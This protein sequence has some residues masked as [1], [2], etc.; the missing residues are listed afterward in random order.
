LPK[1]LKVTTTPYTIFAEGKRLDVASEQRG[2]VT[3]SLDVSHEIEDYQHWNDVPSLLLLGH[4]LFDIEEVDACEITGEFSGTARLV[5]MRDRAEPSRT[6]Y[7]GIAVLRTAR[8]LSLCMK[9][10]VEAGVSP[11]A[12]TPIWRSIIESIQIRGPVSLE[13]TGADD[14]QRWLF[15]EDGPILLVPTSDVPAWGGATRPIEA[16][17]YWRTNL[18]GP[19]APLAVGSGDALV[20]T[21]VP[22]AATWRAVER[23]VAFA[24]VDE[25]GDQPYPDVAELAFAA[26]ELDSANDADF[27]WEHADDSATLLAALDCVDTDAHLIPV[28][29]IRGR[30]RVRLGHYRPDEYTLVRVCYVVDV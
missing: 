6:Q 2:S 12:V 27:E 13:Q 21:G 28:P 19:V 23:G 17:D 9:L 4:E 18:N 22:L 14:D 5:E 20:F 29:L 11:S 8:D 25:R 16:S 3:F 7:C 15:P 1:S 24:I 30:K 10:S 26:V